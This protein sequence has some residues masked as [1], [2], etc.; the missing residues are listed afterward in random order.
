MTAQR[1]GKVELQS[2]K[3]SR[4]R[5]ADRAVTDKVW[6]R[7]R[8]ENAAMG[9]LATVSDGQPFLNSN[10]FVYDPAAHAIYLQLNKYF[11]HLQPGQDY[12]PPIAEELKRTAVLRVDVESWSGKKKEVGD[13]PGAFRFGEL[14]EEQA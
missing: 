6:I 1:P 11:T 14:P 7:A 13:F 4:V 8:L 12:R 2:P 10:L 9:F 5:R 3:T